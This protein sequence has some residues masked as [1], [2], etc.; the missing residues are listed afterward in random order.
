MPK[1]VPILKNWN[2][3][4]SLLLTLSFSSPHLYYSLTPRYKAASVTKLGGILNHIGDK[5]SFKSS[6]N[7]TFGVLWN[8]H[9]LS[10]TAVVT[11]WGNLIKNW[12]TFLFQYLVTLKASISRKQANTHTHQN[13]NAT[14]RHRV[15]PDRQA[16]GRGEG[17]ISFMTSNTKVVNGTN[18]LRVHRCFSTYIFWPEFL[19][20]A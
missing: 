1:I 15:T 18:V 3:I 20:V 12:A 13:R 7:V 9:F 6:P 5:L 2:F 4:L 16:P 11:F 14:Q 17:K 19:A 10:K 8:H